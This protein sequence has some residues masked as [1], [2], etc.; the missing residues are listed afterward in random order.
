MT[1]FQINDPEWASALQHDTDEY[2]MVLQES[3]DE[4]TDVDTLSGQPY[5]GCSDCY[6]R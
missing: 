3:I 6:W 1:S 5:C 2:M 4:D